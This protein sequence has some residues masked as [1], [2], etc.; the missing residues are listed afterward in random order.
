[1]ALIDGCPQADPAAMGF[2]ADWRARTAWR[3]A[4]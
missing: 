2:P 3:V 4:K 1:V